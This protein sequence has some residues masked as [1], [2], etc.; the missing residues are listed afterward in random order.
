MTVVK[1]INQEYL[2]RVAQA[3][4]MAAIKK[5]AYDE[6][7]LEVGDRAVDVGCGPAIDT[8]ELARIVGPTGSVLGLDMDPTTIEAANRAAIDAGVGAY[9]KHAVS[10]ATKLPLESG[11]VDALYCERVLQHIPWMRCQVAVDEMLRV[12]K[13]GGRLVIVDTDWATFSIATPDP[14]LE[15]RIVGE[16]L[17]SF[18]NPF[19]GRNLLSLL[20]RAASPL[21]EV[22]VDPIAVRIPYESAIFHLG[23][24]KGT[25]RRGILTGRLALPEAQRFTAELEGSR[26]YQQWC[27]HLTLVLAAA[28]KGK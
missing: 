11:S 28:T 5:R 23:E 14:A 1:Y 19:S 13:P 18:A 16:H 27:A 3:P 12:L 8:L 4:D 6:M 9:T 20:R 15:R 25:V 17:L 22:T 26:N 24:D 10:D 21:N 7:R 2:K